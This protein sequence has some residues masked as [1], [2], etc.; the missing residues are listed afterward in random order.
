MAIGEEKGFNGWLELN[1]DAV[2]VLSEKCK[3]RILAERTLV[4]V[5]VRFSVLPQF[6]VG[7]DW[8]NSY[9]RTIGIDA[10]TL[11]GNLLS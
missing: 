4:N 10:E 3:A 2:I 6:N 5:R 8:H 9:A 11:I 1:T 7:R